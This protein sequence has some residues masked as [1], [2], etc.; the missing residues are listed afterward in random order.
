MQA[1]RVLSQEKKSQHI[2]QIFK[3]SVFRLPRRENATLDALWL[4]QGLW[5]AQDQECP[6]VWALLALHR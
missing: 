5:T 1:A 4:Q 6:S 3:P 2:A